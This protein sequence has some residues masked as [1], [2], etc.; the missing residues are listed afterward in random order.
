MGTGQDVRH[1]GGVGTGG[2]GA[3][4]SSAGPE[5]P[6][7]AASPLGLCSFSARSSGWWGTGAGLRVAEKSPHRWQVEKVPRQRREDRDTLRSGLRGEGEG[8][9]LLSV[10]WEGRQGGRLPTRPVPPLSCQG[11]QPHGSWGHCQLAPPVLT[12]QT[13]RHTGGR[14]GPRM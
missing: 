10:G 11:L 14:E 2:R 3:Q 5:A 1:S 6:G 13:Q 8:P 4:N 7:A 12:G 9:Q